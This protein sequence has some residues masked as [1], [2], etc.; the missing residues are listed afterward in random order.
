MPLVL[1]KCLYSH[2]FV[3]LPDL[4]AIFFF[5]CV[6]YYSYEMQKNSAGFL[7]F[8]YSHT[9]S[10]KSQNHDES[11]NA[12]YIRHQTRPGRLAC[13]KTVPAPC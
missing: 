10:P 6:H 2:Q 13:D 1:G 4:L 5:V 8:I 3:T 7:A 11:H 9:H 12:S